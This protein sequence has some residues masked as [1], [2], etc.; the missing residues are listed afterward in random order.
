VLNPSGGSIAITGFPD[1]YEPGQRYSVTV[2]LASL[3]AIRWGFQATV[4]N[5]RNK[6]AGKLLETDS[7]MTKV[8]RG[9]IITDRV[10]VEQ[11]AAGSYRG[12]RGM[13]SWTFDWQAPKK[14]RGALTI[15]VCGNAGNDN[16]KP[17]GDLVYFAK[18]TSVPAM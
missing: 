5:G 16:S 11:T 10:Y 15:Y 9:K 7:A 17:T 14:A 1:V 12:V 2:T 3:A 4:L 8:V 6:R 18:I 13:V